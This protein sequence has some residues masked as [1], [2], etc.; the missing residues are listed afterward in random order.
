MDNQI[1]DYS[2][3]TEL[4]FFGTN[5]TILPDLSRYINLKKIKCTET[6]ITSLDNLPKSLK[7]LNCN[8]N[9]ITSLNNLP[10][11]LK[12]LY[13]D[14]NKIISLDNLPQG[15][16]VLYCKKNPLIYDFKPTLENICKYNENKLEKI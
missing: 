12:E 7:Q 3:I 1:E 15:L 16:K 5:L 13:C 4:N 9:N 11:G 8:D 14:E 2:Q 10:E 6:Q